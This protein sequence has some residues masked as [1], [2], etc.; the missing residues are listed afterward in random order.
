MLIR[1]KH[2]DYITYRLKMSVNTLLRGKDIFMNIIKKKKEDKV[3]D[4]IR[5]KLKPG[6][7]RCLNRR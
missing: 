7:F 2:A 5:N 6:F 1:M 4:E 3:D